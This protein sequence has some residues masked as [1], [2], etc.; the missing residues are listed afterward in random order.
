MPA[1]AS[2]RART[3]ARVTGLTLRPLTAA[4]PD[5]ARAVR[6]TR[7]AVA[8]FLAVAGPPL[9]G[10]RVRSVDEPRPEGTRVRGEWVYGPGV[11]PAARHAVIF[12]LHGSGYAVCSARTHRGLTSRL[13]RLTGLPVFACDYRLAP[14][15]R[16]P[17]AADDVCAA[18]SWLLD[19]GVEPGRVVVAGDSAGGHLAVDLAAQRRLAGRAQPAGLVLF[20]PLVDLGLDLARE[21]ERR[22]RD[23]MVSAARARRLVRHYTWGADPRD[24]RLRFTVD[25]VAGLAPMLVQAGGAEMLCADAEYLA[26][27]VRASGGRCELQVWPGQM[28]VFQALSAVVPEA[29][30]ALE[31]AAAFIGRRLTEQEASA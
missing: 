14:R 25:G 19:Q 8:G 13:S 30:R 28:H 29:G 26:A 7:R 21:R 11:E 15:H 23:P 27:L 6:L 24:P 18:F 10:T 2:R 22:T 20:S 5:T 9:R 1:N 4:I 12:Y 31:Q 3:A 16:F 17:S